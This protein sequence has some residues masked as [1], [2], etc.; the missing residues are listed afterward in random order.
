MLEDLFYE[1]SLPIIFYVSTKAAHEDQIPVLNSTFCLSPLQ[2]WVRD[3]RHSQITD[4]DDGTIV[5]LKHNFIDLAK[6]TPAH[7]I[8]TLL[9]QEL[10]PH[11]RPYDVQIGVMWCLLLDVEVVCRNTYEEWRSD[12]G[13]V[14]Y[15]DLAGALWAC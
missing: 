7:P 12:I 15:R 3:V 14:R 4:K 1:R 13:V 5:C 6:K 10:K 2:T 9:Q 8:D 11:H